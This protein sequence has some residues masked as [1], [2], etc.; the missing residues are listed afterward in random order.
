VTKLTLTALDRL[1]AW[2]SPATG[3]AR[4]EAR[5]RLGFA[6]MHY[7]AA[8]VGRRTANWR[9]PED[10]AV[11]AQRGQLARL[12]AVAHD[13]IRND[14]WAR[15]GVA[16]VVN[17]TVGTGI[18]PKPS[19]K[20]GTA[21]GRKRVAQAIED[22]L[23][24]TAIDADG[25]HDIAGLTRLMVRSVVSTGEVII[26]RR[27]RR[28]ADG[29]PVPMQIQVLEPDYLDQT[30]D[31]PLANGGQVIQ[32]VEF[33]AIGRRVAYLLYDQ[34][35][36]ST[37]TRTS[38][39]SSRVP[40]DSVIHLYRVD[41]PGQVRGVPWLAPVVVRLQDMHDFED[42]RLMREKIAAC[43][44]AFVHDPVGIGGVPL[45][46]VASADATVAGD[47]L[48]VDQLEPGMIIT[49]PNG[50]QVSFANPPSTSGHSEYV[51]HHLRAVAACL[52]VTYEA[53]TGDGSNINFAGGRMLW[54]NQFLAVDAFRWEVVIPRGLVRIGQ[55]LVDAMS[56]GDQ[57]V[58]KCRIDWTP[59]RRPL[60]DPGKEV[61]PMIEM[62]K[63]GFKSRSQTI[64]ELG[65]DPEAVEAEIAED[66]ARADKAGLKLTT[67]LRAAPQAGAPSAG[68]TPNDPAADSNADP[69]A[70]P[71][72][73]P[74]A[75]RR[76]P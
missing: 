39:A 11:G 2:A 26:R 68:P 4:A 65:E 25:L 66:N 74:P 12:R 15:R 49:L 48:P 8:S 19:P 63:A 20:S 75:D 28:I 43:M 47:G 50:K 31:G 64:R 56:I 38:F 57:A 13:L 6:T 52:D 62:V 67:D 27:P 7:E 14:V 44:A 3:L 22:H 32:G 51:G 30:Q 61:S 76:A 42:A 18:T 55:W 9:R 59:P 17:E 53:L 69:N 40:A 23:W 37:A 24:T 58:A 21:A 54:L 35:P 1:I 33:D 72:G 70:D 46:T 71:K 5:A 60:V 34:H 29:L 45:G 10:D 41:R 73:A 36:G 16:V